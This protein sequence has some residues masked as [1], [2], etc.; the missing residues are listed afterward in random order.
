MSAPSPLISDNLDHIS[1][2]A[3]ALAQDVVKAFVR[4]MNNPAHRP[5]IDAMRGRVAQLELVDELVA[6]L[7]DK[8]KVH[9]ALRLMLSAQDPEAAGA[10]TFAARRASEHAHALM[11]DAFDRE[12]A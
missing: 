6:G 5:L 10:L 7:S 8:A 3:D 2:E 9:F 4:D 1:P 11:R 12:G